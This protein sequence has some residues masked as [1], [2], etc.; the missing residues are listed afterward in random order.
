MTGRLPTKSLSGPLQK[1]FAT[2]CLKTKSVT[3]E[4]PAK[5]SDFVNV[6]H[7]R[8]SS[9]RATG[10]ERCR[11]GGRSRHPTAQRVLEAEAQIPTE[12]EHDRH[13]WGL[14]GE[15]L[16]LAPRQPGPS[17][18]SAPASSTPKC[19][20]TFP[21]PRGVIRDAAYPAEEGTLKVS[22]RGWLGCREVGESC[23]EN[24]LKEK[25]PA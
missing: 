4:V 12:E 5:A 20:L 3:A 18:R 14:Q 15:P 21:H 6:L 1:I 17:P 16:P 25:R 10:A 19:Q 2:P 23:E 13:I 7:A 9:G 11:P 22:D 8:F 24:L